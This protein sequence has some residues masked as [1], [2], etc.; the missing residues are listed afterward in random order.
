MRLMLREQ[1]RQRTTPD[2]RIESIGD[3][4]AS[5]RQACIPLPGL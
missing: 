3:F 2:E 5:A 1:R 4:S